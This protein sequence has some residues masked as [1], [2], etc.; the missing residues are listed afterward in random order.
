MNGAD[1]GGGPRDPKEPADERP[2][3]E[4]ADD[5]VLAHILRFEIPWDGILDCS[6]GCVYG[7]DLRRLAPVLGIS[8]RPKRE[9]PE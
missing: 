4:G 3:A 7:A 2:G 8:S 9:G 6:G 1:D 5:A